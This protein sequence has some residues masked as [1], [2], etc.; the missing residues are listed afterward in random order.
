LVK[1][2]LYHH[3]PK[4][5]PDMARAVLM[6]LS[7]R[8]GELVLMPMD[9]ESEPRARFEKMCE[10]LLAFYQGGQVSCILEVFSMGTARELFGEQIRGSFLRVRDTLARALADM[11]M[12]LATAL[13]RAEMAV[14]LIQGSLVMGRGLGEPETF[15]RMVRGLPDLLLKSGELG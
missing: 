5:K 13:S 9:A 11:G 4:G 7:Q 14:A 1:A 15:A 3:F 10:G 8:F 12:D 6:R 2:S